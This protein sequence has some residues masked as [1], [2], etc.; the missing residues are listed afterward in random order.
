M[1]L[2]PILLLTLACTHTTA[3][4]SEVSLDQQAK[5]LVK[6]FAGR[7]KPQLKSAME[8][9]GPTQAIEVCA[10]E[11]PKIADALSA[12]SGWGV[13]R[14]SLKARNASRALPDPWEREV[15]EAFDSRREAGEAAAGL[16]HNATVKGQFRY[17]QAQATEPLC[18]VCHGQALSPSVSAMLKDYYPDDRATGYSLGDVRGAISLIA[19]QAGY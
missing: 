5:V 18:L 7:L 13:R 15:L 3:A 4:G 17:M 10:A 16:N 19:P 8:A 1:R 2:I 9:G 11:A 12:E 6:T 14:V